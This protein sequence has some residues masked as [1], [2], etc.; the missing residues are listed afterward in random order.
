MQKHMVMRCRGQHSGSIQWSQQI[1]ECTRQHL[2]GEII[3]K[4][5]STCPIST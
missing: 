1:L 3:G 4:E 2:A 5:L